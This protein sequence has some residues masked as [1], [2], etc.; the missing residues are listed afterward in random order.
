MT[1]ELSSF[2]VM[3][4]LWDTLEKTKDG[5]AIRY[6]IYDVEMLW[7]M[8]FV[9]TEQYSMNE[10]KQVFEP[11]KQEDGT[12]LLSKD[13]FFSLDKYR[14]KGEI[15]IPFDAMRINEGLYTDEGLGELIEASIA[16]SCSLPK[17]QLDEF[18]TSLK[19]L[20]RT[21]DGLVKIDREAK[22]KINDVINRNPSPLR[23]LEIMFD[24]MLSKGKDKEMEGQIEGAEAKM[25]TARAAI[26]ASS[27]AASPKTRTEAAA[28]GLGKLVK[29]K[30]KAPG[31]V[32]SGKPS[33]S[34]KKIRRSRK[35]T[36]G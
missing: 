25:A 1:L 9:D 5:K 10:W 28:G 12:Y 16:P 35:G 15:H 32:D 30:K 21:P 31:E 13:A 20:F 22:L 34:L 7:K 18:F 14:Y 29:A 3:E 6:N 8:G 23:N 11:Y 17:K 36:R 26:E 27:F 24:Q 4:Y 2:D 33:V 19:D